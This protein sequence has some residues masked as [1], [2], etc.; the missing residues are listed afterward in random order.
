MGLNGYKLKQ[1]QNEN[2]FFYRHHFFAFIRL[3]Q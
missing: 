2:T 3:S 1:T